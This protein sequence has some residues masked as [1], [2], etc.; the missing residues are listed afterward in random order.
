LIPR[1]NESPVAANRGNPPANMVVTQFDRPHNLVVPEQAFSLQENAVNEVI[2]DRPANTGIA[3]V[4]YV[5]YLVTVI[6]G[7]TALIGVVM[8]YLYRDEA[9]AW[10]RTHYEFQI[11]TFWI[12]VLYSL[13]AGILCFVF[14]GFVLFFVIAVWWII[15][16]VKG[17][18]YLDRRESYPDYQTWAV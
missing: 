14:I 13:I 18:R 10:L 9:P 7:V 8:A 17:L 12:G 11:R 1:R 3:T 16:C 4:I 2:S 5:L 15:R 6:S